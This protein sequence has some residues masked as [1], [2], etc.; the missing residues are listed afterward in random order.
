MIKAAW[1]LMQALYLLGAMAVALA[2]V[3]AGLGYAFPLLDALNHLQPFWFTGTLAALV[4][5]P[6]VFR[7]GVMQ[8][9]LLSVTATGFLASAVIVVPEFLKTWSPHPIAPRDAVSVR[10]LTYNIFGLNYDMAGVARM[11]TRENPDIVAIQEFFP[12]QRRGL[13]P[14]LEAG[15][16]YFTVCDH[17]TKRGNVALYSRLPFSFPEGGECL[18]DP[19]YGTSTIVAQFAP[20]GVPPFTVVT[21]HLDWPV[22]V[23][24]LRR[25][26]S[27]LS[28]LNASY[29]RKRDEYEQLTD[30]LQK[31]HGPLL[32]AGDFNATSWSYS[33]RGFAWR[34]Q[35]QRETRA[36]FTYPKLLFFDRWR[37]VPAFLPIDQVMD[38]NGIRVHEIRAGDPAG[39]DHKPLIVDFTV[40]PAR[41]N[42]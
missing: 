37:A 5:A 22:Q 11:I 39:S 8:S 19:R 23:S 41:V 13:H 27:L 25:T 15:Y 20:V 36:I 34:N 33:L 7:R 16:P 10:L 12:G 24:K 18:D 26:G 14:L 30:D 40:A 21:T 32:L 4:V 29:E 2:A 1:R 38:R 28:R 3:L 31:V 17:G 9:L 6:L 42:P 35:L